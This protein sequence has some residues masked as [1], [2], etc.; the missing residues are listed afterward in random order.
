MSGPFPTLAI[1]DRLEAA[2]RTHWVDPVTIAAAYAALGDHDHVM[3]WLPQ[4]YGGPLRNARFA[5]VGHH[6]PRP[7][8]PGAAR[9]GAV[10]RLDELRDWQINRDEH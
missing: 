2:A 6:A 1:E 4:A 3:T 10:D 7:A 5:V 8:I 9:E